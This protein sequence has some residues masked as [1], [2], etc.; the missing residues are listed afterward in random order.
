VDVRGDCEAMKNGGYAARFLERAGRLFPRKSSRERVPLSVIFERFRRVLDNHNRAIEIITDMGE[1]LGGDYLFDI[2]YLRSAYSELRDNISDSIESFDVL[3]RGK[4]AELKE[5]FARIDREVNSL[6]F[7][8]D[9]S[10]GELILFFEDITWNRRG[11]TG[12]KN[13]NLAALKNDLGLSVPDGFAITTAAFADYLRFNGI[14]AKVAALGQG[15]DITEDALLEIRQAILGGEMSPAMHDEISEA[16]VKLREKCGNNCR[17]AVRS[18]AVEEDGEYSFAGQYETMLNVPLEGGAVKEAYQQVLAS[19]YTM[20]SEAYHRQAGLDIRNGR[21]AVGCL[22]M[23]N[24]QASGVLYSTNPG[25]EKN[26]LLISSTWGLGKSVV[27]GQTDADFY[28]IRKGVQPGILERR[29]G[30]KTSMVVSE[31]KGGT[32]TVNT[33][34]DLSGK[35]SLSDAQALELARMGLLIEDRFRSPQDVEWA[36]GNEG[37]FSILQARPLRFTDHTSLSQRETMPDHDLP[38]LFRAKGLAVQPGAGAGKVFLLKHMDDLDHFPRGAVL[39]AHSDSSNFVRIMPFASAIITDLGT[40]T[41]HMAALCREFRVPTV[42]NTGDASSILR[43][44]QEVTVLADDEGQAT[45]YEGIAGK[46]LLHERSGAMKMEELYEFRK[47][48]FV[49]RFISPLHLIDPLLENFVP[50]GCKTMHDILRF[51][52]EKAVTELIESARD[53]SRTRAA[54]KLDL[55]IPAGI[56]VADIGGGLREMPAGRHATYEDIASVPFRAILKGMMYPGAWHA[57]TVSL[58]AQDFFS[59]MMRMPDIVS[60]SETY[61]RYNVAVISRDYVNLNLRFGYHYNMMDCYCSDKA[62][63]NHI[64]FRF[65]GGATDILKRSRRVELI[66]RIL[67]EYGF[68]IKIQGDLIIARLANIGREEMEHILDQTGRLIAFTRQL[69]AVLQDDES[70]ARYTQKFLSG[71]YTL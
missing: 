34:P 70:I 68:G 40:P 46:L 23:V 21:M 5:I 24:A 39:V 48:R 8:S 33:P 16:L 58:Q 11:E 43:H 53:G 59:S 9:A 10:S 47:K 17:L 63:N 60:D 7:G 15:G 25:G 71:D 54:L 36:L 26:T 29:L 19:L 41:S 3:T 69:D 18:S 44:G 57:E 28:L 49:L 67:R 1:K 14:A 65:T 35:S 56:M 32:Q 52:H 50:A 31:D 66:S 38:V 13:A 45:V 22:C 20:K 12:G 2:V 37:G 64:Y 42:V 4:Y 62:R 30:R 6:L 27:E 55:P 51:I 61:L